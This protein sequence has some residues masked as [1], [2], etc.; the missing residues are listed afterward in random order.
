[1]DFCPN[2]LSSLLEIST[3]TE[4]EIFIKKCNYLVTMAKT[5]TLQ[6]SCNK[7]CLK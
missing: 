3:K 5:K 4:S 1:M 2:F 7:I 6:A